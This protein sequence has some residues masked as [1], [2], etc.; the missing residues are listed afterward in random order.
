MLVVELDFESDFVRVQGA[1]LSLFTKIK[2]KEL[3]I[4]PFIC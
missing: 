3:I 2:N 1:F 4:H